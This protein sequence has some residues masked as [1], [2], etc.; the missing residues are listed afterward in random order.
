MSEDESQVFCVAFN[1][2][3]AALMDAGIPMKGM[4]TA[5][6]IGGTLAIYEHGSKGISLLQHVSA[7]AYTSLELEEGLCSAEKASSAVFEH[8]QQ[9]ILKRYQ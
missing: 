4:A 3:I 2:C 1:A 5:V 6:S 9:A 8:F 7:G